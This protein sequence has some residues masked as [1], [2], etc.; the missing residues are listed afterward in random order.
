MYYTL[1][2]LLSYIGVD[3]TGSPNLEEN[4]RSENQSTDERVWVFAH[5]MMMIR[6][7]RTVITIKQKRS[8]HRKVHWRRDLQKL[9]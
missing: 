6:G 8:R 7:S 5:E 2:E 3:M 1:V 4:A 9:L